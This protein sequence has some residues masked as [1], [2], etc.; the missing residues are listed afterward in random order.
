MGA[1]SRPRLR[2]IA[3]KVI[4]YGSVAS[5]NAWCGPAC[6]VVFGA[7]KRD[8]TRLEK[9]FKLRRRQ[10]RGKFAIQISQ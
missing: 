6:Q 1:L 2:Q 4:A 3:E 7:W 5:G 10:N 8:S 9:I